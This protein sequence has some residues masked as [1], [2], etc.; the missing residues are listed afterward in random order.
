MTLAT[1]TILSNGPNAYISD[2]GAQA[3]HVSRLEEAASGRPKTITIEE[4]IVPI[5]ESED[6]AATLQEKWTAFKEWRDKDV[7]VRAANAPSDLTALLQEEDSIDEKLRRIFTKSSGNI[8]EAWVRPLLGGLHL[9][10]IVRESVLPNIEQWATDSRHIISDRMALNELC[11]TCVLH[12]LATGAGR[13]PDV[14]KLAVWSFKYAQEA[15]FEAGYSGKD[16]DGGRKLEQ[17]E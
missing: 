6:I 15:Y 10:K 11:L 17:E 16:A 12:H 7:R 9:R 3:I 4:I 13:K 1:A 5:L 2:S 14:Q 8:G